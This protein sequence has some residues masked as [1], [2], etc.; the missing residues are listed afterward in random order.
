MHL[1]DFRRGRVKRRGARSRQ[2]PSSIKVRTCAGGASLDTYK[3]MVQAVD[4]DL[5]DPA[6]P[7]LSPRC[8]LE[9][10]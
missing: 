8:S 1:R 5:G 7:E 4:D 2:E 9:P 6:G 10:G 3:Q